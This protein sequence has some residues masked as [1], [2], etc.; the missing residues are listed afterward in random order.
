MVDNVSYDIK[1]C[2]AMAGVL[3]SSE[4]NGRIVLIAG[5]GGTDVDGNLLE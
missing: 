5:I 3:A 1:Q 4:N 2:L